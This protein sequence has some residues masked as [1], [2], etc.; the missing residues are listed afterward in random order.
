[1]SPLHRTLLACSLFA[2]T[3]CQGS[4]P[5]P[6]AEIPAAPLEETGAPPAA[7]PSEALATFAGG[8]FW[9]METPFEVLPGVLAVDSGYTGGE[10]D[11]PT[12]AQVCAGTTGHAEAV[13]IR[14]D[15]SKI[16]YDSLLEVLWRQIDPTDAGGQFVDRG[17]QYR[18]G[19]FYHDEAQKAAA[20][21]SRARLAESGRFDKPIVTEVTAFERF[22]PAED[23]HQDFYEKSPARY[24]SYRKG[25]GRDAFC[26]RAWAAERDYQPPT[27]ARLYERP[28]EEELRAKLTDLQY[29]VTQE[30]ATERP[31]KNEYWDHHEEGIYVD[32]VTGEPLFSSE[33]KYDSGCGWPSFTRPLNA[34]SIKVG[35]DYDLGYPRDELRSAGGNSHLGHVFNDGPAPTG[36][37]YCINSASLRFVPVAELEAQGYGEYVERFRSQD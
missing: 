1:M 21:A 29:R 15:P 11:D 22:W 32:V 30:A 7:P 14:Y 20:L 25:S 31:Y 2:L 24:K 26:D 35:V 3:A 17:D 13:Q 28:S 8:C 10:V 18:S 4:E 5:S 37:R 33:D 19:I 34:A 36:L 9:C 27:S 16:S 12:Y 6:P 23:Y